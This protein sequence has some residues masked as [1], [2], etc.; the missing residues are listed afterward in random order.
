MVASRSSSVETLGLSVAWSKS[1]HMASSL[2]GFSGRISTF[3]II[4]VRLV[5]TWIFLS[6][7]TSVFCLFRCIHSCLLEM[8]F[9]TSLLCTYLAILIYTDAWEL[10]KEVAMVED[11]PF[12][13]VHALY[14]FSIQF[15]FLYW[16]FL[17]YHFR[18]EDLIST[19]S[20]PCSLLILPFAVF[21]T[22]LKFWYALPGISVN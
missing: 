4:L 12:A 10:L 9:L 21:C 1:S 3:G 20:P 15:A 18:I 2:L 22:L 6:R 16:H 7:I 11:S 8:K 13:H 17:S 5:F 19:I 14:P